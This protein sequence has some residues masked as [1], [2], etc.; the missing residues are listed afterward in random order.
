MA[1]SWAYLSRIYRKNGEYQKSMILFEQNYALYSKN[2][3]E[4]NL[5]A[6]IEAYAMQYP[7]GAQEAY[8]KMYDMAVKSHAQGADF[9]LYKLSKYADNAN[10]PVFY[11]KIYTK[12][13]NGNYAA[14]AVANLFWDNYKKGNYAKA[15]YLGKKKKKN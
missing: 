4:D 14:D 6:V 1:S 9:I 7:K 11:N 15:Y 13:P 12:Y 2:I 5:Q 8:R 10:K 3:D